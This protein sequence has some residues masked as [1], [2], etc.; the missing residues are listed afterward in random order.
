MIEKYYYSAKYVLSQRRRPIVHFGPNFNM[1]LAFFRKISFFH[2][3][4]HTFTYLHSYR[5]PSL[6]NYCGLGFLHLLLFYQ[7]KCSEKEIGPLSTIYDLFID[8]FYTQNG[9]V[10]QVYHL[11]LEKQATFH[12]HCYS[13]K[14]ETAPNSFQLCQNLTSDCLL[15]QLNFPVFTRSCMM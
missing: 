6:S 3:K 2:S 14:H 12:H 15:I 1:I 4:I 11:T 7:R 10:I 9:I 13:F 5:F 8:G